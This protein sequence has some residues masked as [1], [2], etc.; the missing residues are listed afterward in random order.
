MWKYSSRNNLFSGPWC[1]QALSSVGRAV[2]L[3]QHCH[4]GAHQTKNHLEKKQAQLQMKSA[5]KR[6]GTSGEEW[7]GQ[8]ESKDFS[9]K[10]PVLQKAMA[11]VLETEGKRARLELSIPTACSIHSLFQQCTKLKSTS[12]FF[13]SSSMLHNYAFILKKF[14][15]LKK[16]Q[17]TCNTQLQLCKVTPLYNLLHNVINTSQLLSATFLRFT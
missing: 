17:N 2:L 1:H 6:T 7:K 15:S 13:L 5:P 3:L 16:T 4:W 9:L 12:V 10:R 11:L 14:D 8:N